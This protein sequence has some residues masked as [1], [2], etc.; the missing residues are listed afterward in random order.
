MYSLYPE[1]A[2]GTPAPAVAAIFTRIAPA[3]LHVQA[4]FGRAPVEGVEVD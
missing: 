3:V 1:P 2:T 4:R